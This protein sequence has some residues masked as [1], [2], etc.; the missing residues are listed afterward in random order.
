MDEPVKQLIVVAIVVIVGIALIALA[1]GN[2]GIVASV[3]NGIKSFI[4]KILGL[5]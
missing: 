1:Q 2:N 3:G 4:D 5:Q